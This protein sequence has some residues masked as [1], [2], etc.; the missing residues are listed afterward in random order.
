MA[1]GPTQDFR[2]L[3]DGLCGKLDRLS[4]ALEQSDQLHSRQYREWERFVLTDGGQTS[5]TGGLTVGGAQSNLRPAPTGW[6]AYITAIAVTVGGA[7]AAATVTNYNGEQDERNLFDYA[8]AMLG[9]TP[10][11]LV[12]FYDPETVY[13]EPNDTLS[14]VIAGAVASQLVTVRVAGKRRQL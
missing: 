1:F 9:S 13:C 11:R 14:I 12:A 5:G 7:S 4:V 3:Y 6:E 8:N 10:A 2:E